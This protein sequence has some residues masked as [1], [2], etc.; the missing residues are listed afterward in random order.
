MSAQT[1]NTTKELLMSAPVAKETRTY[2][3][4]S[5]GQLID[6]TLNS[7]EQAGFKLDK[8]MYSS[9]RDGRIANGRFS[10]SNVA[11][12][13]MC[14]QIGW[15]NSYDRSLSLKFAIGAHIFI[16]ANGCVSGDMGSF[17]KKHRGDIQEFTPKNITEYIKS[18]GDHFRL[19]QK[20][21]EAMKQVQITKRVKAEL[22]GRMLI[23]EE[24]ISSTQVHVMMRELNVP[25]YNYKCPDSAWELYNYATYAMKDNH[26]SIWMQRHIDVHNFFVNESGLLVAPKQLP[27]VSTDT[28]VMDIE[29]FTQLAFNL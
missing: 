18:A 19:L 29:K 26:P 20:D 5:H 1:Y 10:I 6:L 12:T 4:I 11:D 21:R 7:I 28:A 2:K 16:C 25:T 23:E 3:P 17:R 9:A 22:I 8:E 14:L 13:E 15:Q 24:I 27:P